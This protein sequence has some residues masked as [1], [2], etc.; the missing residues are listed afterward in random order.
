V[1][2]SEIERRRIEY[3]SD[4]HA[5]L[6]LDGCTS[7]ESDW[8]LVE[9]LA[10]QLILHVLP[11]HSSEN[12]QALGLGLLRITTQALTKVQPDSEKS[13]QSNQLIRMLSAWYVVATPRNIVGSFPQ[14]GIVVRREEGRGCLLAEVVSEDADPAQEL[15]LHGQEE[16]ETDDELLSDDK[17]DDLVAN[18][19]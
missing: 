15:H 3:D 8:C 10:H 5:V 1:F 16:N 2:F 14:S 7:H 9:G 13:E 19:E 12:K 11:P 18:P 17:L 4:G 6:I